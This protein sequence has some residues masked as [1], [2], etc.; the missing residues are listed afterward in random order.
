MAEAPRPREGERVAFVGDES[1]RPVGALGRV[2]QEAGIGSHVAWDDS[3]VTLER[4]YDLVIQ[5]GDDGMVH[6]AALT[7]FSARTTYDRQGGLGVVKALSD[8]GHLSAMGSLVE[9]AYQTFT[10]SIREDPSVRE[11]IAELDPEEAAEVVSVMANVLWN[12]FVLEG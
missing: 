12:D 5:P 2:V 11:V 10:A 7:T 1:I 3:D 8:E 9:S 4:N 6:T